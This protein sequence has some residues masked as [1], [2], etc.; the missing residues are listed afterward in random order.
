MKKILLLILFSTIYWISLGQ[1]KDAFMQFTT[2]NHDFGK[3][4]QGK[5]AVYKF[6][7]T[8]TG[9]KP[10][11]IKDVKSSCGCTTPD[12]SKKPVAPGAKGY[13]TVSY[14]TKGRPGTF[15][16]T[17]T[18]ISNAKNS[19]I[20]LT[21]RG[22][23]LEQPQ[24]INN[25]YRYQIGLIRVNKTFLNFGTIFNNQKKTMIIKTYNP[26]DKPV[27][28]VAD[29]RYK[30]HYITL[31]IEPQEL[32]P[33]QKGIIKVIY[34]GSKVNDWDY[35]RGFIYLTIDNK[36]DYKNKIQIAATIKEYFTE[37]QK[38]NPPRIEFEETRYNFDT[39]TEGEII[40]HE[41]K[42]KNTGKSPLIIRKTRASCG[43]TAVSV[44]KKPI[45]PGGTGVIKAIFNSH[46]KR[47]RQIKT[48]TV[49]TNCP[50]PKYNRILLRLEGFVK[51]KPKNKPTPPKK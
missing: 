22:T 39:I 2:T 19:P 9:G 49:I 36:R 29:E 20:V 32:K 5:P 51:P 28:I 1:Y 34:D 35:V 14:D 42:F 4:E 24:T 27:K 16:K 7:F 18:V 30:P 25:E 31:Q 45:P 50:E 33:K 43:C 17:I 40:T 38:K 11:I 26:T 41:F 37:E 46:G 23:V 12:W 6:E 47:N 48:I 15:K 44:N 13:I 21:V 10:I 8:N 3:I